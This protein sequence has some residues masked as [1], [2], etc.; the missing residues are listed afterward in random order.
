[1]LKCTVVGRIIVEKVVFTLVTMSILQTKAGFVSFC[2]FGA[3]QA[4]QVIVSE[5]LHAVVMSGWDK[6]TPC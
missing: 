6:T 3:I 2:H 1:M 5:N 4:Q